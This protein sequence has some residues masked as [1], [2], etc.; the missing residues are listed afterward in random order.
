MVLFAGVLAAAAARASVIVSTFSDTP[1]GYLSLAR[2]Q[3]NAGIFPGQFPFPY[4]T[5][6]AMGFV[7]DASG[8]AQSV[9]LPLLF[10]SGQLRVSLTESLNGAPGAVLDSIVFSSNSSSAVD[11]YSGSFT[12]PPSLIAGQQYW[13]TA[14]I[15]GDTGTVLWAF[16]PSPGMTTASRSVSPFTPSLAWNV[17]PFPWDRAAFRIEGQL[18]QSPVPEPSTFLLT[19]C[20][21]GGVVLRYRRRQTPRA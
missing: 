12:A 8:T 15:A 11:L 13:L 18:A 21:V 3:I 16:S 7:P 1:P 19:G 10:E 6:W 17:V 14:S 5:D 20:I 9:A 4:R 2:F